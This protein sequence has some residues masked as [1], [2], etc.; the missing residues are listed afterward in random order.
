MDDPRIVF[1]GMDGPFSAPPLAA[2][3]EAGMS[4]CALVVPCPAGLAPRLPVRLLPPPARHTGTLPI[5]QAPATHNAIGLARQAGLPVLEVAG[6]ADARV[7]AALA[8]LR[9]DLICV[10]CFPHLLPPSLCALPR[11]GAFNLHPS[12]LPAYRG[13]APLFW[14]FHD[15]LE[16][17][18]VTVHLM[19]RRADS[20]AIVAQTP[21]A[22][23]DGVGYSQAERICAEVGGRLLVEA[24]RAA[25]AGQLASRPQPAEGASPAPYPGEADFVITPAWSPRRACNFLRGM[26]EWGRPVVQALGE[27]PIA[28]WPDLLMACTGMLETEGRAS[29]PVSTEQLGAPGSAN[30]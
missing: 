5:L 7:R 4:V 24:V 1:F 17:A 21:V 27:E 16:R 11:H 14:V 12:L 26:A 20:G 30:R 29:A 10:A 2:L 9:P 28:R 25:V 18:G 8:A 6:L 23:P 22:L 13:P 3:L 19:E 15:G